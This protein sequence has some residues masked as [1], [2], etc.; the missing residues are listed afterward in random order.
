MFSSCSSHDLAAEVATML[1]TF[2]H[3]LV[4]CALL[5]VV[6]VVVLVFYNRSSHFAGV[7][8]SDTVGNVTRSV[9][10]S[11]K[12][13]LDGLLDM[14]SQ[15]LIAGKQ[16]G[17]QA[18]N[19]TLE[20]CPDDPPDLIGPFSVEFGHT[21]TWNEVRKKISSPLQ[22]GGRHKPT[23]CVSKHKVTTSLE[24]YFGDLKGEG[25][26]SELCPFTVCIVAH[27]HIALF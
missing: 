10:K 14:Q 15:D 9:F 25:K 7:P 1:K 5:S 11:V 20:P 19:T 26:E 8:R 23:N 21:R 24:H 4:L 3:I 22:D 13:E 16:A 18:A 6:T 17:Q 2:S 12:E 27:T